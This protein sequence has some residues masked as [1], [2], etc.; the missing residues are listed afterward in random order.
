MFGHIS[1]VRENGSDRG[2][3]IDLRSVQG[4]EFLLT[5]ASKFSSLGKP[6]LEA[7]KTFLGAPPG[8][9][10]GHRCVVETEASGSI[11]GPGFWAIFWPRFR[12]HFPPLFWCISCARPGQKSR[13]SNFLRRFLATFSWPFSV[14]VFVAIFRPRYLNLNSGTENDHE[15]ADGK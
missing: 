15:N 4:Q 9:N 14:R 6:V 7:A 5:S 13:F 2:R 3:E 10:F 12:G 1:R 11:P 8:F